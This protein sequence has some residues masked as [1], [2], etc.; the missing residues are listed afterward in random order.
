MSTKK[1]AAVAAVVLVVFAGW[2]VL[3]KAIPSL[4]GMD[5]QE[6]TPP[7]Q[8]ENTVSD[9]RESADVAPQTEEAVATAPEAVLATS[10]SLDE[11]PVVAE[12]RHPGLS[13]S[14]WV[15]DDDG[16][17]VEGAAVTAQKA[18]GGMAG[19]GASSD[20]EGRF[21]LS[22]LSE[23]AYSVGALKPGEG[24]G[25]VA[26]VKAG[27]DNVVIA[28]VPTS[29]I[30]WRVYDQETGQG[31]EDA[32]IE[33]YSF[34]EALAREGLPLLQ[35]LQGQQ[36]RADGSYRVELPAP[37]LYAL[38]V[39]QLRGYIAPDW[40]RADLEEGED[41][42]GVDFALARGGTIAGTVF[43]PEGQPLA[44]AKLE[45]I[46]QLADSGAPRAT[47][48]SDA[49][50][51]YVFGVRPGGTYVVRAAH[52]DYA[53]GESSPVV[54]GADKDI[55]GVDVYMAY[56]HVVHGYVMNSAGSGIAGLEVEL[57][58][59]GG[60]LWTPLPLLSAVTEPDGAFAIANVPAGE[61]KPVVKTAGI[62]T[63]V[64]G[65]PFT[66]PADSDLYDVI[67]MIGTQVEG[68]ISGRL[69]GSDG[70]PI[71]G[72]EVAASSGSVVG[73]SKTG[74][75]GSYLIEGLGG[76]E[77]LDIEA[78][79]WAAGYGRDRRQG[80]PVNSENVDFVLARQ[81]A[82]KGRVVD[83]TTGRPI[84]AFEAQWDSWGWEKFNSPTGEFELNKIERQRVTVQARAEG[85]GVGKTDE[86]DIP[87]AKTVEGI[88]IALYR[89]NEVTGI[90]F[91]AG[92]GQ[93]IEG[94]RIKTFDGE[95]RSEY[96]SREY[97]WGA[98]DPF[99]DAEGRFRLT[100]L[101]P[102][103]PVNLVAWHAGYAPAVRMDFLAAPGAE[104][105]FL[106]GRGGT[107]SG[108]VYDGTQLVG[109]AAVV[110]FR[111]D[112]GAAPS[113]TFSYHAFG[114]ASGSGEFEIANLP[115]GPYAL[116]CFQ[117][118]DASAGP[119][120]IDRI[121][122]EEGE[123]VEI[124]IQLADCGVISGAASGAAPGAPVEVAV[125]SA[126]WPDEPY[127]MDRC[128]ADGRFR[129]PGLQAGEYMIR[130]VQGRR[131]AE[132][133]VIL[134]PGDDLNIALQLP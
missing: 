57:I 128:D 132:Q 123:T 74:A 30:S 109:G 77:L 84:T 3:P 122:V 97:A 105:T 52:R 58:D 44:G 91:D 130:A 71:F 102:K 107:I 60:H 112:L 129:I 34:N 46:L 126:D 10:D 31:I 23:G 33:V 25:Y 62:F 81:G 39:H 21:L 103:T 38:R 114:P 94:A 86:I 85:Y 68:F 80:V 92:T 64:I 55:D 117:T 127:Y 15:H 4:R 101:A 45:L 89:G 54:M 124:D 78:K 90:V 65:T 16:N 24:F 61:Y 95:L 17:A 87:P 113:D 119:A 7:A 18:G 22:G 93:P 99:T 67:I 59:K 120:W 14:G 43:D 49:E 106:L 37:G 133:T 83:G 76:A 66:M 121:L 63:K 2:R 134:N 111:Q 96:L 48:T 20:A 104:A 1:I 100:G 53:M 131:Q 98:Q 110:C 56:G 41:R 51:A 73:W 32:I 72:A 6:E 70:A 29:G 50:G 27:A 40:Q 9:A 47:A 19:A 82:V 13:I 28:L 108:V 26:G 88:V 75:D 125:F 35:H 42:T 36:T 118:F 79:G 116:L 8:E 69:T 11:P 5:R 115:P 12:E